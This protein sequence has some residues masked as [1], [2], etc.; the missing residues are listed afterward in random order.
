M[1]RYLVIS[2]VSTEELQKRMP[3]V[4]TRKTNT[5]RKEI[6][7]R[8]DAENRREKPLSQDLPDTLF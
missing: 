8:R 3:K 2:E 4:E 7:S 6:I 5:R 1:S